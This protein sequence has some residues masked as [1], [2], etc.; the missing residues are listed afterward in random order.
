MNQKSIELY[1]S[2]GI[3]LYN[4]PLE[5]A[6]CA[7]H[8]NG[9]LSGDMWWESNIKGFFPVGEVNGTHGIYRPGGSALNSGQCG[10]M[11]AAMAAARRKD[12]DC[13]RAGG[14][15][16][17]VAEL[18]ELVQNINKTI[19][20]INPGSGNVYQTRKEIGELMSRG[21]AH[22]RSAGIIEEGIKTAKDKYINY[23]DD[24]K[25]NNISELPIA[26]SNRDLL[27]AQYVYLTAMLDYIRQ[28]GASRGSYMISA[29]S[30]GAQQEKFKKIHGKLPFLYFPCGCGSDSG[31]KIQEISL[32]ENGETEITWRPRR[33]IPDAP[34]WFENVWNEYLNNR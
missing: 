18:A 15:V 28:G 22:I 29:E 12:S 30:G 2:N 8:N 20:K 24:I 13:A 5:I 21:A 23:W 31:E 10:G 6:V 11:R 27:I 19:E 16:P 4:E 25:L 26:M 3:D 34:R 14:G 1:K 32:R 17:Q 9:G 33:P 7:Q